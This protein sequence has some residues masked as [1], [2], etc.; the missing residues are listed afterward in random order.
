VPDLLLAAT[1]ALPAALLRSARALLDDAFAGELTEEDWQHCLGGVHA[2]L[3]DGDDVVGHAALVRRLLTVGDRELDTGYVEGVAVRADLRRRGLAS[4]LLAALE[5][6][7]RQHE[8]LALATTDEA[9]PFYL[10]RGWQ[11]WRGP[12]HGR[13]P[14]GVVRTPDDDDA[15]LVL[16]P[17][18]LDLD[19]PITCDGRPGDL[20]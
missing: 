6:A 10:S 1:N 19:A 13:T 16:P 15:L 7:G 18:G 20:W 2:L 4:R 9:L 17:P 5:E 3:L 12:T 14:D 8:L 11:R